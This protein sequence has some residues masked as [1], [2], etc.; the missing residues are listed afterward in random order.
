[1]T[2]VAPPDAPM[3]RMTGERPQQGGVGPAILWRGGG[4]GLP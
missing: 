4:H 1:M 3:L 2:A